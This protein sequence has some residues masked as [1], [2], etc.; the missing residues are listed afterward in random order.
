MGLGVQDKPLVSHP[1]VEVDGQLRDAGHCP[2]VTHEPLD[3]PVTVTYHDPPRHAQVAV[4]P[5]VQQGA[6]V[7]LHADLAET[8][9]TLVGYR[10]DP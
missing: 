6:A 3:P 2:V 7:D 4:Q 5:R 1:L 10:L 8:Q 9:T